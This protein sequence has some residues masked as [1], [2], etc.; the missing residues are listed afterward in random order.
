MLSNNH[1]LS[2]KVSGVLA[3]TISLF[4]VGCSSMAGKNAGVIGDQPSNVAPRLVK[5]AVTWDNPKLFG[6]IGEKYQAEGDKL[7]RKQGMVKA[8]G[9]HPKAVRLDG[10]VFENGA[11]YC[12]PSVAVSNTLVSEKA[13]STAPKLIENSHPAGVGWDNP[14]AFGKVPGNLQERGN[15]WCRL[16]NKGDAIGYHPKAVGLDGKVLVNGGFFCSE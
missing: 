10:K 3:L 4:T 9:Y 15:L 16:G 14:S 11:F 13:S 7:C 8:I 1:N 6:R 12:V 2:V 5:S